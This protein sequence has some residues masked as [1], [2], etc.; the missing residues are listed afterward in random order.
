LLSRSLLATL[1]LETRE[2]LSS[3]DD[4]PLVNVDASDR[5]SV[6]LSSA[7]FPFFPCSVSGI[8]LTRVRADQRP[9]SFGGNS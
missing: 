1:A 4:E 7:N 6:I 8:V 5:V 3:E 9:D 2:Q